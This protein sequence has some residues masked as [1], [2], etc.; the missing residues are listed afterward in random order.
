MWREL[1]AQQ[2]ENYIIIAHNIRKFESPQSKLD[3]HFIDE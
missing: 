1:L 2:S 3:V